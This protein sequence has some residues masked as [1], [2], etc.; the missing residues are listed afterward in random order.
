MSCR[1]AYQPETQTIVDREGNILVDMS[2]EAIT[3]TF[4]I[5]TF[6]E[7]ELPTIDECKEMWDQEPIGYKKLIN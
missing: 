2:G 1:K 6:G 7:M 3:K 4:H 5:R